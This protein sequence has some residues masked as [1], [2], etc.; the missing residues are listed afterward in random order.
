M[1]PTQRS[2]ISICFTVVDAHP[3]IFW[4]GVPCKYIYI[5]THVLL[6]AN[7]WDAH[8]TSVVAGKYAYCTRTMVNV[9]CTLTV[10]MLTAH[11]WLQ[12]ST[13]TVRIQWSNQ[14]TK[15]QDCTDLWKWILVWGV[16]FETHWLSNQ[17][18]WQE[19][20]AILVLGF[21]V[22]PLCVQYA[23]KWTLAWGVSFFETQVIQLV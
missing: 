17:D 10:V 11:H 6:H 4:K 15:N 22:G 1:I 5:Y 21:L 13:R 23:Y 3:S 16:Y 20:C 8:C 12:G 7:C 18:P 2:T 19:L 14:E 9:Y